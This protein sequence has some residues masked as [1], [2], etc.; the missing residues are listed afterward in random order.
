MEAESI[1]Q[2]TPAYALDALDPDEERDYEEHLA[3]CVRCR[4][5]LAA[6]SE[7]ATSL[8]YGVE[9][10]PP[11]PDLRERILVQARSE[12]PNV[13]PL[14]PAWRS[15]PAAVAAVAACAAL[16]LGIWAASLASSLDSERSAR[17]QEQRIV[18]IVGSPTSR[19][20]P[21]SGSHGSLVLSRS[22]A[23]ALVV[24]GLVRAP[25]GKTYECWVIQRGTPRRAGI[26]AGGEEPT[27][28][29]LTR[30][31]PEGAIVAVTLERAG[32]VDAPTRSP[33]TAAQ[34]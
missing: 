13:V 22:G 18:S 25:N 9:S 29:R 7:A 20:I 16:G 23:A 24:S 1:H 31:V 10:P 17:E 28:V 27:A 21:L 4:E 15:W 26:F 6:F 19:K 11:P 34:A 33:L 8:A 3:R 5:D 12:R 30:P 32:G 14:R 2:L